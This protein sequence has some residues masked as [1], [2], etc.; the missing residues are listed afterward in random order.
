MNRVKCVSQVHGN[1]LMLKKKKSLHRGATVV[2][3]KLRMRIQHQPT[4]N[5]TVRDRPGQLYSGL[6]RGKLLVVQATRSHV[7][8]VVAGCI[9]KRRG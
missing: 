4:R 8:H 3:S 9:Y 1:N 7:L 2:T 5:S 6:G